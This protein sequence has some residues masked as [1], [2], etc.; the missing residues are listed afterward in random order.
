MDSFVRHGQ[1]LAGAPVMGSDFPP[2]AKAVLDQVL[3]LGPGDRLTITNLSPEDTDAL[4]QAFPAGY[5]V[6]ATLAIHS[7]MGHREIRVLS[8]PDRSAPAIFL[9]RDELTAP[10]AQGFASAEA[11]DKLTAE[12]FPARSV[13]SRVVYGISEFEGVRGD[14]QGEA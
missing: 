14:A 10:Y 1:E 6:V 12:W 4:F 5:I 11:A 3:S 7:M 9:Y 2:A 8:L 13:V